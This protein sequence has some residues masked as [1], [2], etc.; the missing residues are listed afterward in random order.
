MKIRIKRPHA[1]PYINPPTIRIKRT[2]LPP[3]H[4]K[5][6]IVREN[7]DYDSSV[8]IAIIFI[9]FVIVMLAAALSSNPKPKT[10]HESSSEYEEFTYKIPEEEM[11]IEIT[12]PKIRKRKS[13]MKKTSIYSNYST[14]K[15][16]IIINTSDIHYN[17][18]NREET[19]V[20][21]E[22]NSDDEIIIDDS[23]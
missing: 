10:P 11:E 17:L 12:D 4:R 22:L 1:N 8:A 21:V 2:N 13:K 6:V 9:L 15:P 7:M 5:T 18:D 19:D 23:E 14:K 3:I 20:S 16:E